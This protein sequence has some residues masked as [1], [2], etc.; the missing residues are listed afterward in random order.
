MADDPNSAR[1]WAE[2]KFNKARKATD[3]AKAETDPVLQA[4]RKK[5]AR[6]KAER[7]AKGPGERQGELGGQQVGQ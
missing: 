4:T 1:D 2:A 3:D 6:L 5:A 7:L